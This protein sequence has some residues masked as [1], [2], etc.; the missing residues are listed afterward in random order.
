MDSDYSYLE[1]NYKDYLRSLWD[2]L[3]TPVSLSGYDNLFLEWIQI[4]SE[5]ELKEALRVFEI[6]EMYEECQIIKDFLDSKNIS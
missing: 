2:T 6:L 5:W 1:D 4:K 3:I